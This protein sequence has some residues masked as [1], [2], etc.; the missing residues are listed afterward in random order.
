[1]AGGAFITRKQFTDATGD[2]CAACAYWDDEAVRE[3]QIRAR[4]IGDL[5][6]KWLS[7]NSSAASR[8]RSER[9]LAAR[10]PIDS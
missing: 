6:D 5:Q 1:M 7:T 10:S 4:N 2:P 8:H 3:F 9:H